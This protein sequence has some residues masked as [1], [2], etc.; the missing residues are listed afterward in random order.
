MHPTASRASSSSCC[1]L[2]VAVVLALVVL[3]DVV[4]GFIA[5]AVPVFAPSSST[6]M[7]STSSGRVST[8]REAKSQFPALP[9]TVQGILF[10]MDGTLTDSDTLHF[11]AYRETFLKVRIESYGIRSKSN[12]VYRR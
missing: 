2:F 11:E 3:C 1:A 10:D 8:E 5:P 4:S 6:T 7:S 12:S 9:T